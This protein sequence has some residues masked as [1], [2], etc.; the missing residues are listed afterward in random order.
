[1]Q[2]KSVGCLCS[3]RAR[4]KKIRRASRGGNSLRLWTRIWVS[5]VGGVGPDR[6]RAA[7]SCL[8]R[9]G[10]PQEEAS[11]WTAGRIPKGPHE[12]GLRETEDQLLGP[13]PSCRT[14]SSPPLQMLPSSPAPFW[15]EAPRGATWRSHHGPLA[16]CASP[17]D[18]FFNHLM[19]F[20]PPNQSPGPLGP[21][22]P[23]RVKTAP[24]TLRWFLSPAG[25]APGA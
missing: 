17:S 8:R 25:P 14:P 22:A 10:V 6:G 13:K 11:R 4:G 16:G 2:G 23:Q 21:S 24:V 15:P 19:G 9:K 3:R 12:T 18:L 7:S 1:M 5:L 20:H